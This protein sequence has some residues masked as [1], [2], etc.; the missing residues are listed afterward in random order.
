M[1]FNNWRETFFAT[2]LFVAILMSDS[3]AFQAFE[4]WTAVHGRIYSSTQERELRLTI[5]KANFEFVEKFNKNGK[6]FTVGL[7]HFADLTTEEI[8]SGYCCRLL[9]SDSATSVTISDNAVAVEK[10]DNSTCS[11]V[12]WVEYGVVTPVRNQKK[13]GSCWAFAAVTG[14]EGIFGI[15]WGKD[16]VV[17]LSPQQLVDCDEVSY[18]CKDGLEVNAYDYVSKRGIVSEA[19]YPYKAKTGKCNPDIFES[20]P[21]VTWINR[22]H[23][24]LPKDEQALTRAVC[25]QPVTVG[26][27][28]RSAA[29]AYYKGGIFRDECGTNLTHSVTI[30]GIG[31][32][33][34][35]T[36]YWKIKNSWGKEWGEG[37]YMKLLKDGSPNG[38]CGITMDATYP[39]ID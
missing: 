12:D 21:I 37:G 32:D 14:I 31:K 26:I 28:T 18:G 8:T 35:G 24:V 1:S 29:F 15:K 11:S 5:F 9:Q 38:Q 19:S 3:S 7:N 36:E 17:P 23:S 10:I 2:V 30:V 6:G 33:E 22:S 25:Q 20:L 27:D 13:C 16:K 34:S 39:V 4:E